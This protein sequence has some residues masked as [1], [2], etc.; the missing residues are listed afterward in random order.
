[1]LDT[2]ILG[3][4]SS[5]LP[6]MSAISSPEVELP[7]LS[8]D[9]GQLTNLSLSGIIDQF[10]PTPQGLQQRTQPVASIHLDPHTKDTKHQITYHIN[11]TQP[12]PVVCDPLDSMNNFHGP[13][14]SMMENMTVLEKSL[15]SDQ[16]PHLRIIEQPKSNALRFRYQCE[17][18][19]AGALQGQHSTSDRKTFPKIQIVGYKGPAV[20][21]VSCVTHDTEIPKA[22]P[23]NLVSPASVGRDG[24]KK[25]VCTMNVNCEDMSLEF[26]HL[27]IQCVRKKDIEESLKQRKEIRVDP[28]RQGFKHMESPQSI[29]LNAVKLC[30]QAFLENPS[31]PGKYT[32]ILPPVVSTNIFDAKAKKELQIM[33]IS[34]IS[35]PAEGGRKIII[36]CE[37]V[38]REDIKVRFYDPSNN[39]EGWGEFNASEV[40]KQ[41]AISLKTP[42]YGDGLITEK[43]KVFVELVKPSDDSTSEPQEFFYCPTESGVTPVVSQ[44]MSKD[45]EKTPFKN[46]YNGGNCVTEVKKEKLRIK[47]ENIETGWSSAK[48]QARQQQPQYQNSG[49]QNNLN[50]QQQM[51][52]NQTI[53]YNIKNMGINQS[54]NIPTTSYVPNIPNNYL[55]QLNSPYTT[56]QQSPDS[57]GF[58]ELN[59]TSSYDPEVTQDLVCFEKDVENL[60]GKIESFS[61]S[62][63]IEASLNMQGPIDEQRSNGKRSSKTAKLESG[64]NIVPREMARLQVSNSIDTPNNS[65]QIHTP[66]DPSS[67]LASFLNNCSKINDL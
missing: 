11:V 36:L 48:V 51:L 39:W 7:T 10:I 21:V 60:S 46:L 4:N 53:S 32:V 42:K 3:S 6:D 31:T 54:Y 67:N 16:K 9:S 19:G 23:H 61:L 59:I 55:T 45:S 38:T 47:Q 62:D 44:P 52:N 49:Y 20:V 66:S 2:C 5:S 56:S 57:Q 34:D 26:Q 64:S 17:G 50:I 37:K 58:S 15:P 1:M 14:S 63:A 25:G 35:S 33:D 40:H 24:C 65:G 41:Y 12:N 18:R 30:F 22:H 27:G 43:R 28:Y 13:Q 8:M 29:D